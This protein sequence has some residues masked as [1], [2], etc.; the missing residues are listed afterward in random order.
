[1]VLKVLEKLVIAMIN[2]LFCYLIIKM[3]Y[4]KLL[5]MNKLIIIGIKYNISRKIC[6]IYGI[7]IK[8]GRKIKLDKCS[9]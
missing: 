3:S 6:Y 7:L 2:L 4:T 8:P 1:M 5:L 9:S